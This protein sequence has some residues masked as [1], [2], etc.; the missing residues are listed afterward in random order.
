V[1]GVGVLRDI[2]V[3]LKFAFRIRE[4]RSVRTDPGSEFIG[5]K[6]IVR[7]DRHKPAVTHLHLAMELQQPLV[8]S[9]LFRTVPSSRQHEYQRIVTL[10][11]RQLAPRAAVI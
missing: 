7:G 10:Q 6:E 8:L 3:F 2:Q 5:L 1:F 9:S 4:K 11:L